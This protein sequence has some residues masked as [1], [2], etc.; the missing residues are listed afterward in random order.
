MHTHT[1]PLLSWLKAISAISV[2]KAYSISSLGTKPFGLLPVKICGDYG[3]TSN[4]TKHE[5]LSKWAECRQ[6]TKSEECRWEYHFKRFKGRADDRSTETSPTTY[7]RCNC[8][9]SGRRF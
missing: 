8:S 4:C 2:A 9:T 1:H 7:S 6:P 5:Y 3:A